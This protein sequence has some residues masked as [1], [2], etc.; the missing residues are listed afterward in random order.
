MEVTFTP[1]HLE[2]LERGR[3]VRQDHEGS[4][5]EALHTAFLEAVR[6]GRLSA[7]VPGYAEGV[8]ALN[9]CLAARESAQSG[10]R[11]NL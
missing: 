4:G 2:V 6:R 9:V 3:L 7:D 1:S 10:Q 11:V 5:L 8:A